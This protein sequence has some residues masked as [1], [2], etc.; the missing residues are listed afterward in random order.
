[1]IVDVR[2]DYSKATRFTKGILRTNFMRMDV[3]NKL[4]MVARAA[5]RRLA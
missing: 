1:V 5:W 3:A 2:I 4:R